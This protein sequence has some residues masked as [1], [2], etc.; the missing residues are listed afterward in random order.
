MELQT[1]PFG[2][3]EISRVAPFH[4]Q[5]STSST[6][7][8]RFSKQFLERLSGNSGQAPFHGPVS[9]HKTGER[10]SFLAL[11]VTD[12]RAIRPVQLLSR[13]SLEQEFSEVRMA[14]VLCRAVFFCTEQGGFVARRT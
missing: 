7:P 3:G 11:R 6:C 1:R 2:V 8:T 4:A 14:P 12:K 9:L 10:A 13:Q 5:E